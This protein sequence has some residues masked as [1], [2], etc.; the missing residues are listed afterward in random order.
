MQHANTATRIRN[1]FTS[2]V[3]GLAQLLRGLPIRYLE[4]HGDGIVIIAPEFYWG[5]LSAEQR[6]SQIRLKHDYELISEL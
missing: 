3:D 1:R 4:W 6:A 2:V 5:E